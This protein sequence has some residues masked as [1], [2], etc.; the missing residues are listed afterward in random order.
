ML[1]VERH[2]G[3]VISL[4]ERVL[5]AVMKH[6]KM[7]LKTKLVLMLLPALLGLLFY[8]A[9]DLLGKDGIM[10]NMAELEMLAELAEKTSAVIHEAQ[11]ERGLS[12][13]FLASKGAKFSS[14]L[15]TQRK[16]TDEKI[17]EF[18]AYLDQ[19]A[20]GVA[21]A[22]MKTS[23]D[24]TKNQLDK[25][26]R[27]RESISASGFTPKDSSVEL[28]ER[29]GRLLAEIVPA[30]SK[31]SSLVQ[32]MTAASE[33]HSTGVAQVNS[34]VSQINQTTQQNAAAAEELAATSEEK[35]AQAEQL[36]QVMG[37][38]RLA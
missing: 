3:K 35:S 13:G 20:D 9:H 1:V 6:S 37:F 31:T 16:L 11:V 19:T 7:K 15:Q 25:L 30:I 38:F 26:G 18:K 14:E 12:A 2:T 4:I 28:A 17:V 32:E 33:E 21:A 22:G 36:Q 5:V 29:A 23:I 10:K 34:A 8:S 27:T 24:A